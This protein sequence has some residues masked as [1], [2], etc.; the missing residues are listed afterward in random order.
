MNKNAE[1][2]A[3]VFHETRHIDFRVD[4]SYAHGFTVQ[5]KGGGQFMVSYAVRFPEPIKA[6]GSSDAGRYSEGGHV[7]TSLDQLVWDRA[8]VPFVFDEGDPIGIYELS[9]FVDGKLREKVVYEVESTESVDDF[10][11]DLGF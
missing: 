7:Y 2:M 6:P 9:I 8:S 1:G 3:F 11:K 4:P 10:D 5:R